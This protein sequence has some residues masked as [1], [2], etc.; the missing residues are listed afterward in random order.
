MPSATPAARSLVWWKM[1]PFVGCAHSLSMP[2]SSP[3]CMCV[4]YFNKQ[5]SPHPL[6]I[7]FFNHAVMQ[8][9]K[10]GFVCDAERGRLVQI[11]NSFSLLFR[12]LFAY[13]IC[14]FSISCSFAHTSSMQNWEENSITGQIHG[15]LFAKWL[16]F[17]SENVH[18]PTS[19]MVLGVEIK[20]A[21]ENE[22][23][24][25]LG[26]YFA[27]WILLIFLWKKYQS[28]PKLDI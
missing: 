8:P 12:K 23:K 16:L 15:E 7:K 10:R 1:T 21:D 24:L 19:L 4:W 9:N 26:Q 28:Q 11:G 17:S 18:I 20:I 2:L 5:N 14:D 25:Q 6:L 13:A 22:R 3:L 27:K